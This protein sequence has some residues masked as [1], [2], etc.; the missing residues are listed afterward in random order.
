ME[1]RLIKNLNAEYIPAEWSGHDTSRIRVVGKTVLMLMD[2]CSPVSSGDAGRK[3]IA[4][5]IAEGDT[6]FKPVTHAGTGAFIGAQLAPEL[7]ERMDM[8]SESGVLVAVS[9]GAFLVNEDGS[10]WS[11]YK[12][13]PGDRCY[14]EKYAGKL[15]KG[16]DGVTYRIM[17]Y[18]SVG[19]TY[20]LGDDEKTQAQAAE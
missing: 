17:D 4:E 6:S 14:V 16:R 7:V 8:A 9:P 19:A 1:P 13:Q 5:A 12:P 10:P 11:G 3:L 18:S 20:D 15:I 2:R